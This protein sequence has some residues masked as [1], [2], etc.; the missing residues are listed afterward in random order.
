M[1]SHPALAALPGFC[2]SAL[3]TL[4]AWQSEV[5]FWLRIAATL[6]AISAGLVSIYVAL[7]RKK[8]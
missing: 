7:R 3:A 8:N 6:V 2:V 1:P 5:E 4:T